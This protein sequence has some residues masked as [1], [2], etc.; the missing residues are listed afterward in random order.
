MARNATKATHFVS[1]CYLDGFADPST[2]GKLWRYGFHKDSKSL[3]VDLVLP[4]KTGFVKN[5]YKFDASSRAWL[6][7]VFC[8][9]E[10]FLP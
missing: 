3:S 6:E 5:Q 1:Q 4:A 2:S 9:V 7:D 8:A 10:G